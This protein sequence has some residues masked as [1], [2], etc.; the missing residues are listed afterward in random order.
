MSQQTLRMLILFA[1]VSVIPASIFAHSRGAD[2]GL[3]GAP[4]DETCAACHGDGTVNTAGGK[5]EITFPGS[6][7]TPGSTYNITIT[8]TDATARRWGFEIAARTASNTE[9]GAFAPSDGLT[10]TLNGGGFNWETHTSTGTR[11]GTAGPVSFQMNWTAPASNAGAVTFYVAANAAN[12]NGVRDP[13][14]HIY[15][16]SLPVNAQGSSATPAIAAVVQ[17]TAFGGGTAISE[18]TWIEIYGSNLSATTRPWDLNKDFTNNTAPTSL[19]G[20]GVLV[21]NIPAF[22]SFVSPGQ[23][24]AQVPAISTGAGTSTI[25]VT[26]PGGVQSAPVPV[27][28]ATLTPALLAPGGFKVGSVQYVSAT[29]P[30]FVT[31]VGAPGFVAGVTSKPARPG[32]VI[33]LYGVGCGATAPG[34]QPGQIASGPTELSG[35]TVVTIGGQNAPIQF[36]GLFAGF[37][38]LYEVY[39]TVPQVP[40]GDQKIDLSVNGVSTGQT[41]SITIGG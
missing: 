31:F 20:V 28:R 4:G 14:D 19:D 23:V 17:A 29:F 38:G 32:D 25:V 8:I 13:G 35:N 41:L 24:N 7:Y 30:D 12:N 16:S 10:Q 27:N 21:D 40:A 34:V 36:K 9:A 15:T 39:V 22:L 18:G 2:P 5:V 33:I 6:G 11:P 37:V 3:S 26:G 1:L